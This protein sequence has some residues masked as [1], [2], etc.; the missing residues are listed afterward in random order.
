[1]DGIKTGNPKWLALMREGVVVKLHV[2]RWRAK[3][4]L[5][6][7]DLGLPSEADDLIGDL[8]NLG[9]KRLLPK[10]LASRLE[11]IE[12][13]GRK[14]L[15]RNGFATFWGTFIPATNFDAWKAENDAHKQRYLDARNELRDSYTDIV[16]QLTDAYRGAARAAF[17]RAK[18]LDPAEGETEFRTSSARSMSRQDLLDEALFVTTFVRRITAQIPTEQQIYDSFGWEEE[19]TYIPLPSLLAEDAAEKD[20]IQAERATERQREELERDDLW[21]TITIRDEADRA[22]RDALIRMNEEVTAEARKKKQQM[23]DGFLGDLVK[24]LRAT[25][26]EAT[27][28]ILATMSKNQ[29]KLHPRSV[30]QLRNLIEQVG[31]MNFFGDTETDAMIRRVRS[32]FDQR[33]ETRNVADLQ[34]ALRDVAIIT[35]ASLLDL[36]EQPRASRII[37]DEDTTPAEIATARRRLD[38]DAT[39][40]RRSCRSFHDGTAGPPPPGGNQ[41]MN[42]DLFR[43]LVQLGVYPRP[44]LDIARRFPDE[45]MTRTVITAYKAHVR[46]TDSIPIAV[47]RLQNGILLTGGGTIDNVLARTDRKLRTNACRPDEL[48]PAGK[49]RSKET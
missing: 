26:Y 21:R 19:Y 47:W 29:G 43:Q 42:D 41:P 4:R 3:S 23:I 22:R 30:V 7:T 36:G 5:D 14:A 35:R 45:D 40:N 39:P 2:R 11:A 31:Q 44:A 6:L 18:A 38:L 16:A 49:T 12:S 28:D 34:V 37:G 20:R 46:E 32:I 15:E 10:D 13:A 9:D 27:T 48:T 1:M 33:P 17:R 25:V 24:Q 8:L